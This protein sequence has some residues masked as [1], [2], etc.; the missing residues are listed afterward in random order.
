MTKEFSD[1]YIE[2]IPEL[3]K[4]PVA[5]RCGIC[6][7]F[8]FVDKQPV[9]A[10]FQHSLVD[11]FNS[12]KPLPALSIEELF[13]MLSTD[14]I[15]NRHD[16][17]VLHRFILFSFHKFV[18]YSGKLNFSPQEEILYYENISK[19]IEILEWPHA[20]PK[21]YLLLSE[22][23]RYKKMWDKSLESLDRV[24]GHENFKAQIKAA[25]LAGNS[26]VFFVK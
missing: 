25:C 20:N 14:I 11:E 26:A 13:Y 9:I 16:K 1:G 21:N 5:S 17:I 2:F 23:Y 10:Q 19:L 4:Y 7:R 22:L 8:F 24:E 6:G 18:R 12:A 15:T 3:K